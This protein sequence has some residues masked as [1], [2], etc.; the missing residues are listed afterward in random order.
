M[1]EYTIGEFNRNH[2]IKKR[3]K[4]MKRRVGCLGFLFGASIIIGTLIGILF[5]LGRTGVATIAAQPTYTQITT[6]STNKKDLTILFIGIDQ[7][8]PEESHLVSAWLVKVETL[9]ANGVTN[10]HLSLRTLY[11]I[12]PEMVTTFSL[13][14]YSQA[15]APV[16]VNPNDINSISTLAPLNQPEV[17]WDHIIIIDEFLMN[18]AI[19]LSDVNT[20]LI[21]EQPS[22]NLF[23]KPWDSPQ[24][25]YK[26]QSAILK[27]FC[28]SPEAFTLFSVAEQLKN[29][30]ANHIVSPLSINDIFSLWQITVNVGAES[31][32]S[33]EFYP[34]Q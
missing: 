7:L 10:I 6:P 12:L 29:L 22:K 15:H 34:Q 9:P 24:K 8:P 19:L 30:A 17:T 11:P 5:E 16:V 13:K 26:Q 33:C 18:S 21:P 20:S 25:A 23:K 28:N 3:K 2:Y 1:L 32:V 4:H 14:D 27:N 31:A